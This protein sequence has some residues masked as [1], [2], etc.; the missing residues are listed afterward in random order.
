MNCS[1]GKKGNRMEMKEE[2]KPVEKELN[3]KQLWTRYRVQT[4]GYKDDR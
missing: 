2:E 1:K 4:P 3:E